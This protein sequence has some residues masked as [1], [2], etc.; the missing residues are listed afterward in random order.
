[1]RGP[2]FQSARQATTD[3]TITVFFVVLD[4]VVTLVGGS[5][6]PSHPGTLAWVLLVVQAVA[7]SALAVRRRFP[8]AVLGVLAAFTLAVTL[9]IWPLGALTPANDHNL[10]APYAT[11]LAAYAPML[12]CGSRRKALVGVAVLTLIVM[13]P[14][15]PSASVM[16]IGLLRTAVGPL[17]AVYIDARR[18]LVRALTERAERAEREKHLIAEQARADE[19]ARLASEMHDVVSHR[20]SLMVL[21]AGALRMTATDE[22][23]RQAAEELRVGGSQALEELRDLIGILQAAP[24][25]RDSPE[26][27]EGAPPSTSDFAELAADSAAAGVPAELTADGDPRLASPV[28]AHTAYR[29]VR[30]ALT[31]VRKHAPGAQASVRVRYDPT[32]VRIAIRNTASTQ[33]A[34]AALAATGSGSGIANLRQRVELIQGTLRAGPLPDGGFHLEA[35]LPAYVPTGQP[36]HP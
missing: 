20:V 12:A 32:Q 22:A 28:V 5:W 24:D 33:P 16:T 27:L 18:R 3:V 2:L 25:G 23:T 13:R 29:V 8:I 17:L 34:D 7:C 35:T 4:T 19:R 10:W 6:W 30:E 15:E 31:N 14:W 9:L 36:V 1:M 26:A 21:Q 11:V